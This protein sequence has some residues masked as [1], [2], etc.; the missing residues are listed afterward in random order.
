MKTCGMIH[1]RPHRGTWCKFNV[2]RK[3]KKVTKKKLTGRMPIHYQQRALDIHS[4]MGKNQELCCV[5]GNVHR[6]HWKDL[7]EVQTKTSFSNGFIDSHKKLP[8]YGRNTPMLPH[9][10]GF[11]SL[12][13]PS[14]HLKCKAQPLFVL[15]QAEQ[16][17]YNYRETML[18]LKK[19]HS[20]DIHEWKGGWFNNKWNINA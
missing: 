5:G 12:P 19:Y 10:P 3:K 11:L 20:Q 1:Q 4:Q 6:A 13:Q 16:D 18:C 14:F 2:H 9:G 17:P 7:L 8:Q 15:V